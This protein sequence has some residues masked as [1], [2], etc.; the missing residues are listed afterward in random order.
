MK[1]RIIALILILSCIISC[2]FLMFTSCQKQQDELPPGAV[3]EQDPSLIGEWEEAD[4]PRNKLVF[5][6][7]ACFYLGR[8]SGEYTWYTTD[9]HNLFLISID[10]G[11]RKW[12]VYTVSENDLTIENTHYHKVNNE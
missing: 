12:Y 7:E 3:R 4:N 10:S 1:R 5:R 11:V 2:S 8:E 9:S 6:K